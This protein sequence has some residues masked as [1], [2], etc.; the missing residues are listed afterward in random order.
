MTAEQFVDFMIDA[1][2]RIATCALCA[3]FCYGVLGLSLR[4]T[5]WI[6]GGG[7]HPHAIAGF[8]PDDAYILWNYLWGGLALIVVPA[9]VLAVVS[10]VAGH[11][12]TLDE[13][14]Q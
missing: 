14:Q 9:A 5:D 7:P 6:L 10:G 3:P 1:G 11:L 4:F 2:G 8:R 12:Q 13:P